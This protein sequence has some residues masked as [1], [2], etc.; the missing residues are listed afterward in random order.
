MSMY[1]GVVLAIIGSTGE[2][3][4]L[5]LQ[6]LSHD[7]ELAA[8]IEEDR[9]PIFYL[10]QKMWWLGIFVFAVGNI[11]DFVAFGLTGA[12]VVI[13]VGCWALVVNLYTAPKILHESRSIIDIVAGG[14]IMIGIGMAVGALLSAGR[15]DPDWTAEELVDRFIEPSV[16]ILIAVVIIIAIIAYINTRLY[17]RK[18]PHLH[19]A[20]THSAV[21]G[22]HHPEH[23]EQTATEHGL[24]THIST[25]TAKDVGTV[26]IVAEVADGGKVNGQHSHDDDAQHPHNPLDDIAGAP[27]DIPAYIRYQHVLLAACV[28]TLTVV[29]AKATSEILVQTSTGENQFKGF[30]IVIVIIFL[31]SLPAQ[32]H[33]INVSLM[34][35]DALFHI[36]VF[37][38][39]WQ[40]GVTVVGGVLYKEFLGFQPWQ[41]VLYI[42]G[43]L[44]LFAGIKVAAKRL[45]QVEKAMREEMLSPNAISS[46][47]SVA[48]VADVA[49]QLD[50]PPPPSQ[51]D[52]SRITSSQAGSFAVGTQPPDSPRRQSSEV[53]RRSMSDDNPPETIWLETKQSRLESR[54]DTAWEDPQSESESKHDENKVL[55]I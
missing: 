17:A 31:F 7:R 32:L 23:H 9:A 37:Y 36:P 30:A 42:I 16:L 12:S 33:F 3:L 48:D 28:G 15:E 49:S 2:S 45:A 4:G 22:H 25:N 6:K 29:T 46:R 18:Y 10:K 43:I 1:G 27:T 11:L 5:T 52:S 34:I 14:M 51:E 44:I 55:N 8:A 53:I 50:P 35:N 38:V 19:Q 39:F 13:V 47:A 21:D 40:V 24:D 41:W 26:P 54:T 20:L